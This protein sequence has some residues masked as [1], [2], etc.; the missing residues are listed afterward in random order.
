ML[1]RLSETSKIWGFQ[2]FWSCPV[3]FPHYGD[4]LADIG[5]MW[6]FWRTCG[7]KCRGEGG[8]IFPTLCD[9]CCLVS[10]WLI[11]TTTKKNPLWQKLRCLPE[12]DY[13]YLDTMKGTNSP[14]DR[15]TIASKCG[16]E[17]Q[18]MFLA[19]YFFGNEI[20]DHVAW[21]RHCAITKKNVSGFRVIS[22]IYY[23]FIER[24][25]V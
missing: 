2:A 21:K 8:G 15:L 24:L 20:V 16:N 17:F 18:C 4:P 13:S 14:N 19:T 9:E 5:H 3:D 6:G 23:G 22:T 7:S 12:N 25:S 1:F 10:L 11:W